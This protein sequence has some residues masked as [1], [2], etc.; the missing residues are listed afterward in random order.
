MTIQC[1]EQINRGGQMAAQGSKFYGKKK[2]RKQQQ[3]QQKTELHER[4]ARG[5]R[6]LC[7]SVCRYEREYVSI[8]GV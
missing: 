2:K 6:A 1:G 4:G 3:Q 8:E 5:T 7:V